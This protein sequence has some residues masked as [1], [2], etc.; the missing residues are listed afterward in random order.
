MQR[1]GTIFLAGNIFFTGSAGE[2]D[3][4]GG[5][6]EGDV[7]RGED[8]TDDDESASAAAPALTPTPRRDPEAE[9]APVE[10]END[11]ITFARRKR[12]PRIFSMRS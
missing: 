8:E 6:A 10:E 3:G 4:E 12:Q 2:D 1:I 5:Q 9:E 7:E 11:V